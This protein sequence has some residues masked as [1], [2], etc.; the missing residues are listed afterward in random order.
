MHVGT[1]VV[2]VHEFAQP[3]RVVL[4]R[5]LLGH[6][7]LAPRPVRIN[8]HEQVHRA[9]AAVLVIDPL[10]LPGRGRDGLAHLAD[11]LN[12]ALV[13]AHHRVLRVGRLGI[14]IEHVLHAGHV[15]AIDLR[16]A[17]HLLAPGFELVLGQA[18]AHRLARDARRAR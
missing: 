4:R 18:P 17:P 5:A 10:D 9:A 6:V 16:D 14:E 8:G 12:G 15:L 1:G 13:Q 3:L 2:H 7:H 11:Q